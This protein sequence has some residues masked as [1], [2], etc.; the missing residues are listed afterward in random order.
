MKV[1]TLF[2]IDFPLNK[3]ISTSSTD[4]TAKKLTLETKQRKLTQTINNQSNVN[5]K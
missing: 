1:E 2:L 5:N 3:I 4:T